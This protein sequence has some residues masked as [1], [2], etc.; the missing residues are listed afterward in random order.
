[1]RHC[2][3]INIYTHGV[4]LKKPTLVE[5]IYIHLKWI[6]CYLHACSLLLY[7]FTNILLSSKAIS[8]LFYCS[9]KDTSNTEY[10]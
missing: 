4:C 3:Q 9:L 6:V 5:W 1:M 8:Y 7:F 2:T 10:I